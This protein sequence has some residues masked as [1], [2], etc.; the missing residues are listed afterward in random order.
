MQYSF[1]MLYDDSVNVGTIHFLDCMSIVYGIE[2]SFMFMKQFVYNI[3]PSRT[4]TGIKTNLMS[5]WNDLD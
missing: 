5:T 1:Q 3:F 4:V 2:Q